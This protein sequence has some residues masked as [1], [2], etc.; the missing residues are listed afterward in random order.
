[1]HGIAEAFHSYEPETLRAIATVN[2]PWALECERKL[3]A[4]GHHQPYAACAYFSP[5][6][7]QSYKKLYFW[8][9]ANGTLTSIADRR[10]VCGTDAGSEVHC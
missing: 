8:L 1:M 9:L 5:A 7:Q 6:R 10:R 2:R 4:V 3:A